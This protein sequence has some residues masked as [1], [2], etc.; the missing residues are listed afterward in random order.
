MHNKKILSVEDI[1]R[2]NNI[3]IKFL[4][5][6]GGDMRFIEYNL[7][8]LTRSDELLDEKEDKSVAFA[9]GTLLKANDQFYLCGDRSIG[10]EVCTTKDTIRKLESVLQCKIIVNKFPHLVNED[11]KE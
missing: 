1:H 11:E 9:A 4:E 10:L 2:K 6:T 3:V 8:H 7:N 5:T